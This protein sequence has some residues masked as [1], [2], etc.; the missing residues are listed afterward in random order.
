MPQCIITGANSG[1]GRSAAFQIVSKGWMVV[2]ACRSM[3]KAQKVCKKIKEATGNQEIYPMHVDLSLV[4]SVNAFAAEYFERFHSLDVLINNAADFDLSKKTPVITSEGNETQF[5]TN[6]LAP[7]AL[8]QKLLPLLKES[9]DGRIINISSQGL[10][11]YPNITLDFDNLKGEKR[12]SPASTYYQ[13]KLALL[14]NSLFLKE[15]L[16]GT[17]VSVYAVRVTNVKVDIEKFSH[18]SPALKF[19]Y[20]IKSKFSI[21][22]DEMAKVYTAL[23]LGEKLSGFCYDENM[24]E[25][26]VNKSAYDR[27]AQERL[28]NICEALIK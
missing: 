2:L 19:M 22:P 26:K 6:V 4:S 8:F 21:S 27:A 12:Y 11:L 24:K 16:A 5:A 18:I 25:V 3:E 28:W 14:M 13:T 20:K 15:K 7:F 23:A 1:I 17:H 9:R 10:M